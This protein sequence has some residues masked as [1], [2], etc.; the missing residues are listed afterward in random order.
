[1]IQRIK[2]DGLRD[3]CVSR[4]DL[5]WGIQVPF[6]K[7]HRIYVWKDALENYISCLEYPNSP[8]YLKYWKEN[9]N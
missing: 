1:M 8:N 7:K 4:K 6:D 5:D 3:L 9:K 2:K